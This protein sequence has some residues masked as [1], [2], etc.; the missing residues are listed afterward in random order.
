MNIIILTSLEYFYSGANIDLI[1]DSGYS[2]LDI[3]RIRGHG[4][5]L[6]IYLYYDALLLK[7]KLLET[8]EAC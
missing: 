2:A 7:K 5:I 6:D 3:V 8:A 4:R 1:N